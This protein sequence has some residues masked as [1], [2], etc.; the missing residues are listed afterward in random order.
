MPWVVYAA[1]RWPALYHWEATQ[2]LAHLV[3]VV[4]GHDRPWWWHLELLPA[5]YG[6][7][8]PAT[9]LL[10]A[11]GVVVAVHRL[12]V[13]RDRRVAVVLAWALAPYLV[14]SLART[15][16]YAQVAPA[17]PALLLL[18]GHAA[19]ALGAPWRKPPTAVIAR[20]AGACLLVVL[21]VHL[22]ALGAERHRA[23]YRVCPWSRLYD[24]GAFRAAMRDIGRQRGP[25]VILNVGDGKAIQAMY[26]AEAPAYAGVPPAA[27]VIQLLDRGYRVYL[28]LHGREPAPGP[29]EPLREAGLLDRVTVVRIPPPAPFRGRHPYLASPAVGSGLA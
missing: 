24:C 8:P 22:V 7:A 1:W 13:S 2:V 29:I 10:L 26:Y 14:F 23:D 5:H 4:E 19:G 17:V 28:V 6:G 25:R 12:L 18:V 21:V 20:T 9:L 11:G 27:A 15:R 3:T 16:V